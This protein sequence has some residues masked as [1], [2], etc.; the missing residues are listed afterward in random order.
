MSTE[1]S[2]RTLPTKDAEG[3]KI[4]NI[5][6]ST[7]APGKA[8]IS[9]GYLVLE[10]P[11]VGLVLA[12]DSRFHATVTVCHA[13]EGE[14]KE[15]E[16]A[17]ELTASDLASVKVDVHSP[18][19][20]TVLR[21][22]LMYSPNDDD[23]FGSIGGN[24]GSIPPVQIVPRKGN[25]R[26]NPKG[27]P[28][29]EKTLYLTF[30]YIRMVMGPSMFHQR[31]VSLITNSTQ[32]ALAIKLRADNDFYSQIHALQERQLECTPQN[33]AS[34]PQFLPCP[35]EI[36]PDAT[37][38]NR[39]RV[40]IRKTGMG[41]SA[42]LVTSLVGCLLRFFDLIALPLRI[43]SHGQEERQQQDTQNVQDG[44]RIAHNLSQICHCYAQGK[45]G[46]GFD[47]SSAVYG[48]HIYSRFSPSI[49]QHVLSDENP[50]RAGLLDVVRDS[51]TCNDSTPIWD[52]TVTPLRLPKGLELLMADV[53]GGSES[54]SM[55]RKIVSWKERAIKES[56]HRD[57][58]RVWNSLVQVNKQIQQSLQS[59]CEYED[60][61]D[62]HELV[63]RNLSCK[64]SAQW[65]VIAA[66]VTVDNDAGHIEE[67][68]TSTNVKK[69]ARALVELRSRFFEARTLLKR[70]GELSGVPVEPDTQT[71]LANATMEIPGVIAAGVPGAGGEDALFVLYIKGDKVG[72]KLS[73]DEVRDRIGELWR[74]WGDENGNEQEDSAERRGIGLVCPLAVHSAGFGGTN[75]LCETDLAWQ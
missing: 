30:T 38:Y 26:E 51:S 16:E 70:M 35:V 11:N 28:F 48:S 37:G 57:E 14:A 6:V 34:L 32:S 27:N 63:W 74:Q 40:I 68:V 25:S 21:Y 53:C 67:K 42:T 55:A 4:S 18:Q 24:T 66:S 56:E 19:F 1:Y 59:L 33:V 20:A 5:V 71:Y 7:S 2:R 61:L 69:V 75:G 3:S 43:Q 44:L 64:T 73:S 17:E 49:L 9:G 23:S 60:L 22:W 29:V 50:H 8:L 36:D 46:S 12:A 65:I 52:C 41:S 45:I 13:E 31:L 58:I 72:C 10:A 39:Q 47:V 62:N 54:P 15:E